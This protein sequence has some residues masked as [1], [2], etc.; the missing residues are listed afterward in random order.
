MFQDPLWKFTIECLRTRHREHL[1]LLRGPPMSLE[2]AKAKLTLEDIPAGGDP[3]EDD[4]AAR[5]AALRD[6]D[7]NNLD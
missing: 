3:A 7:F 1:S 2:E 4:L 5:A 6:V